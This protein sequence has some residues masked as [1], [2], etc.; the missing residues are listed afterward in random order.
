VRNYLEATLKWANGD[1][2]LQA[3]SERKKARKHLRNA[4]EQLSPYISTSTYYHRVNV[5]QEPIFQT[6]YEKLIRPK[7]E[8]SSVTFF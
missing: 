8:P 6:A 2:S 1:E 4:F 5:I 3:L 7:E